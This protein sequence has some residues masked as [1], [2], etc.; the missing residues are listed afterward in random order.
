MLQ[1]Q[2]FQLKAYQELIGNELHND[3]FEMKSAILCFYQNYIE[4]EYRSN[5]YH[6]F[7]LLY[8]SENSDSRQ[9]AGINQY[10]LS[11]HFLPDHTVL[12]PLNSKSANYN[13]RGDT[14]Y[15]NTTDSEKAVLDSFGELVK[16]ARTLRYKFNDAEQIASTPTSTYHK[17]LSNLFVLFYNTALDFEISSTPALELPPTKKKSAFGIK[18][19]A[20]ICQVPDKSV[21]SHLTSWLNSL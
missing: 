12:S 11:S 3:A 21:E 8:N 1:T 4:R 18:K 2:S 7:D 20:E 16:F 14:G 9:K 5:K 17:N 15:I 13:G 10:L 6:N 19:K